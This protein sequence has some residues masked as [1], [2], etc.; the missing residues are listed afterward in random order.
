MRALL[1]TWRFP[2][3]L[4]AATALLEWLDPGAARRALDNDAEFL[5]QVLVIVPPVMVLM[6]L[7]Q[8]WVPRPL[9]ERSLGPGAGLRGPLLALLLGTA[10]AGPLYAAFPMARALRDKGATTA[11]LATFLGTW[12]SIKVPMILMESQFVGL[13]FALLRL[14]LTVPA[15]LLMGR[16]ME[17]LA[18]IP[19][20]QE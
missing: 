10:A 11:N 4:A 19:A 20:G 12:A 5:L 7:L 9:V 15:V 2:L 14:G 17:W 3:L 8:V 1:A 16:L 13:R 6:G 18:P